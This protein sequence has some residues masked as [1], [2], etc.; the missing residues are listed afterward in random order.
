MAAFTP[1]YDW[2][3]KHKTQRTPVGEFA[4]EVLK[5]EKLPRE[6]LTLDALLEYVKGSA[7]PSAE[8]LSKA[9]VSWKAF[10]RGR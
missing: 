1:F 8:C 6:I 3:V 9:R 10:E 2:L 5:D 4:R 7:N